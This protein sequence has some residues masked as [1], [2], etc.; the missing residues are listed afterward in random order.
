[1]L[2]KIFLHRQIELSFPYLDE[3]L[4]IFQPITKEVIQVFHTVPY[5]SGVLRRVT[6]GTLFLTVSQ[7]C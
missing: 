4:L 7:K 5:I 3:F 2:G 1:M 6:V